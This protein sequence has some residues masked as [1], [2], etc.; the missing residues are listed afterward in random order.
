M[1]ITLEW[2]TLKFL[3]SQGGMT[4]SFRIDDNLKRN[5]CLAI[6]YKQKDC[7]T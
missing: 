3:S 7:F 2:M 1:N 5:I 4:T 6:L